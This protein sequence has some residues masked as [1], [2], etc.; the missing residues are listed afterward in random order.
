MDD[1]EAPTRVMMDAQSEN[2]AATRH[3]FDG[4]APSAPRKLK[5]FFLGPCGLLCQLLN[6]LT[7]GE[8]PSNVIFTRS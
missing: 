7:M 1:L 6:L 4:T 2:R 3:S 5:S 8:L